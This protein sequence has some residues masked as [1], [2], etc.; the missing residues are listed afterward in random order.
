MRT[1][2]L[3][4]LGVAL[5][6][7]L[8][9]C[10]GSSGGGG[11]SQPTASQLPALDHHV[12]V[13]FWHA[14]AGGSQKPTLE[15]ITNAF[16]ASQTNVT[17]QLQVYP[18]YA[19]LLQRTLAAL[20]A[21]NPPDMAQCYENWTNKYN[22]SKAV[23]DLTPYIGAKDG[24]NSQELKDYWPT[25]LNDAK[26][27]GTY[28]MFP[29]N[30]S[31]YVVYYNQDMFKAAGIDNPPAT[32]DEFAAD[33]KKLTVPGQRWGTDFSLAVGYENVWESMNHEFGGSL[34]SQD[35][36][37]STF[38]AAPGQQA[39][40]L[41]ADLVKNGYAHRVQGFE[42]ENDLGSQHAG[43]I[44]QSIAGYSFVD[45]SVGGKFALKTAPLPA[46]PKGQAV[47]MV[48]TNA[49]VFS[50]SGKDVQQG[51]FQYIKYFTNAQNTAKWSQATGYM[52]VRQSAYKDMQTSFYPQNPNLKV[53]VDQLPHAI[54]APQ[55]AVW[56]QAQNTILTELG[57]I[58]DGKESAKDGLS[59]AAKK[60]DDLLTTG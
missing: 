34:V 7:G 40:Q 22:Q 10:G 23:A 11:G 21:G 15:A 39:I 31:D 3:A 35:Q 51:A 41:F 19:T 56:D 4:T 32:W 42:D 5:A 13:N 28:Y 38:N 37:K 46:G 9:A 6:L 2:Q 17:V 47:E 58:V 49:C 48:G 33:A 44:V 12:T 25:M 14:M 52:P 20:A 59:S 26:L 18:D 16:N 27:N 57:N 54:F 24:L 50:K 43:M 36:T 29:F 1:R 45:R 60:V 8:A 30:K 55:V 53:A